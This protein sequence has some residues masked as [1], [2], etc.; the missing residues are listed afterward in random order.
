MNGSHKPAQGE[1]GLHISEGPFGLKLVRADFEIGSVESF[2]EIQ[3]TAS[4]GGTAPI[5]NGYG[6]GS[7]PIRMSTTSRNYHRFF[8]PTPS[9]MQHPLTLDA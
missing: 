3:S 2:T 5:I 9:G 8:V 7:Q 1:V 4:G 6:G